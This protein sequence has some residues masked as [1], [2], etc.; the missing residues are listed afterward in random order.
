V[1][2]TALVFAV[3]APT[4]EGAAQ[5]GSLGS[6]HEWPTPIRHVFVIYFENQE[7]NT[8]FANGP[9]EASLARTYANASQ[10]YSYGHY[11]LPNYLAATSGLWTNSFQVTRAMNIA[12]LAT[13]AGLTWKQYSES[14]PYPCDPTSNGTYDIYHSPF[15]MYS[16][17]ASNP[18]RCDRDVVGLS[19]FTTALDDHAAPNYA[20]I[21]PNNTDDDH[22]TNVSVGDAWLQQWLSPILKMPAFKTSVFFI[23]YDEGTTDWGVK[24]NNTGGGHLYFVAVSPYANKGYSSPTKYTDFNLLTTTEWLLGLGHTGMNDNW[25]QYPPMTDLFNFSGAGSANVPAGSASVSSPPPGTPL[26]AGRFDPSG[27]P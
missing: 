17:V 26:L 21:V 16:Y 23:T 10:Y 9:Y 3:G 25:S 15:M 22:D 13:S 2:V 8:T 27:R 6:A 11:S 12:H 5:F 18:A 14:I 7:Y 1:A 4:V 19:N 20:L 24:G